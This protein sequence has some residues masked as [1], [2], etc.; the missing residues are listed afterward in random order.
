MTPTSEQANILKAL[1]STNDNLIINALAGTGKT[2]TLQLI[3]KASTRQPI[4][5][6]AF[7]RRI[8]DEA[9]KKFNGT[10]SVRTLNGLGHRVWQ[11]TQSQ[12]LVLAPKKTQDIYKAII[13]A[14]PKGVQPIC[15]EAYWDVIEG[16]S[17]AKI[18]GYIP[19]GTYTHVKALASKEEFIKTLDEVP[20]SLTCDLIDAT[21]T[22]SIKQSYL[23]TIDFADQI[24]MPTLFGGTFPSFPLV[25]GD[26]AQD[27]S[28]I[29][30]KLLRR[31]VGRNTRLCAVGDPWQSIYAFRG[32]VQ[33]GMEKIGE[34]F[35]CTGF[36]LSLSF[37]CPEAI[38]NH[39]LP[40]VPHFRWTKPGGKVEV[41]KDL[42][43]EEIKD[44]CA[45]LCR[46]NA[47]LYHLALRLLRQGRS[48]SVAGSE[49]GPKILSIMRKFGDDTLNQAG[50]LACIESWLNEKAAKGSKSA[51]DTA[52]CMRVFA[53]YG[54]TLGGALAYAKKLFESEGTIRLLTG[55]KA[56]GLEWPLVYHLDPWLIGKHA[57]SNKE[58]EANLSYVIS[59][60]AQETLYE[61]DSGR[62]K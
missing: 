40:H 37:R 23:G 22:E 15:H 6:L 4:L 36:P 21:L 18:V 41:L 49:L 16:V 61:I 44:D 2:S 12:R 46:N 24:Y 14:M 5:Y 38:V 57:K 53:S 42:E 7:N 56:K 31:V 30:H 54:T 28:P 27:F 43:L 62:I 55:H 48:V 50:V 13:A 11:K 58:Q 45:I 39:V 51:G 19:E 59:T 34:R 25:L 8:A 47:P 29:N 33:S 17:K 26:E 9:S 3:E 60:R 35:N 1:Q 52:E 10:T 20:D 32:A